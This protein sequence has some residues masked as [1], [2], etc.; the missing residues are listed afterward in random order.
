MKKKYLLS[1]K[2]CGVE[3]ETTKEGMT[4]HEKYCKSNPNREYPSFYGKKHTK[5]AIEKIRKAGGARE[6]SGNGK[7][8]WYKGI[9]CDSTWELAFVIY[10][11]DK[12][13]NIKRNYKKFSYIYNNEQHNYIPDFYKE[14]IDT[15]YE[16]KGFI[17]EKDL[18]K[19]KYFKNNLIILGSKEITPIIKQIKKDYNV[20][21][22]EDLYE[23]RKKN[24]NYEREYNLKQEQMRQRKI[25]KNKEK[26]KKRKEKIEIIKKYLPY[27]HGT[28]AKITRE[29]GLKKHV[30]QN[31]FKVLGVKMIK[32]EKKK[33][34]FKRKF[35]SEQIKYIREHYV[36]RDKK[37]GARAL[38]RKFNTSHD[39]ILDIIKNK[40]YKNQV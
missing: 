22:I 32:K 15:Y 26:D 8:G 27:T 30:I 11:L 23:V 14:D 35:N 6:G 7:K 33:T 17:R 13:I 34:L 38:G 16:I 31:I 9:Y 21:N 3:K 37:F 1:C 2:F 19:W 29:T 18:F 25:E 39:I 12:K 24:K 4:L 10:M 40:I 5:E 36:P 20:V 28:I